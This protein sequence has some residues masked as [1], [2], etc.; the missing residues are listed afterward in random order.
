MIGMNHI[1]KKIKSELIV[2]DEIQIDNC[3]R[4]IRDCALVH[5]VNTPARPSYY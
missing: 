4:L 5:F 3:L 1:E 2:L